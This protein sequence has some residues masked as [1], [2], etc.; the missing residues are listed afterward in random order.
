MESVIALFPEA[1]QARRVLDVLKSRGF[2][3]EHLGFALT[4]AVTKEDIAQA[5]GVSPE[6]GEPAGSALTMKGMF[7]GTLV[8]VL[9]M[10]PVWIGLRLDPVSQGFSGGG[11]TSMLF[12]AIG[13]L[14]LGGMF[15][16]LAGSDHGNYVKLLRRTGVPVA[17]AEQFYKGLKGGHVMVIARDKNSERIDEALTI[18]RQNGAVK[19]DEAVGKGQ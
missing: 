16:A 15:G 17:Q 12:G 9:L 1:Q 3:R 10:L 6:E 2:E 13:G 14:G 7:L 4:N 18:M 19:L 11:L 5:T 8:G